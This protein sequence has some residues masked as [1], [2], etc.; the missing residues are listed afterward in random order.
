[1]KASNE[2]TIAKKI[3]WLETMGWGNGKFADA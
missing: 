3:V 2:I 1:M